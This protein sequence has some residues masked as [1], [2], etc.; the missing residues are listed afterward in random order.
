MVA[1]L[2]KAGERLREAGGLL[3]YLHPESQI[4]VERV[5]WY[6]SYDTRGY[7]SR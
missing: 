5:R 7:E 1:N 2:V 3:K 6:G 4:D